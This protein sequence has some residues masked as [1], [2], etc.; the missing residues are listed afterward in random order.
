MSGC[1]AEKGLI[2][3]DE[4]LTLMRSTPQTLMTET[5]PL[6]E[7][8]NRYLAQDVFSPVDLPSFSQ[9]AVDG[10]ALHTTAEQLQDSVFDVIG[11]IKAGSDAEYRLL[12][13]QAIRI[14]TGGKVPEGTT[15]VARQEIVAIESDQKIRL[16]EHIKNQY[17]WISCFKHGRCST[18]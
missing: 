4:A 18:T 10:Y 15:H 13:G 16:V 5:L 9:S 2:S 14:F 8:L 6:G 12:D 11:E 17:W 3:I 1:G 7:C